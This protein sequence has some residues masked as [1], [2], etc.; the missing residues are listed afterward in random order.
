M[1]KESKKKILHTLLRVTQYNAQCTTARNLRN[2]AI[3]V[4][5]WP[6]SDLRPCDTE[7]IPYFPPSEDDIWR[8][9]ELR[10]A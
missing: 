3:Q 5:K 9:E 1:L 4:N 8:I 2:I 7:K 10:K 6:I